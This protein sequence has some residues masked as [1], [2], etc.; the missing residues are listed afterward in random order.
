MKC[1]TKCT[2]KTEYAFSWIGMLYARKSIGWATII[3]VN[4]LFGLN[5][6]VKFD[7]KSYPAAKREKKTNK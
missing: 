2:T 3:I 5:L 4:V 7:R 6:I 1:N